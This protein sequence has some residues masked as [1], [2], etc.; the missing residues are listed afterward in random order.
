[1]SPE[2]A[3]C[4]TRA[5]SG[6]CGGGSSA[7]VLG[8]VLAGRPANRRAR[9]RRRPGGVLARRACGFRRG[10]GL[11]GHR[12]VVGRVA[13]GVKSSSVRRARR[14][15]A[16]RGAAAARG[17]LGLCLGGPPRLGRG[18][19]EQ[20]VAERGEAVGILVDGGRGDDQQ[21][22][23]RQQHEDRHDDEGARS[24][25]IA[26]E[27]TTKPIAPPASWS[28]SV[29][30]PRGCR[31]EV[32][33]AEDAEDQGGPADD[34]ASGRTGGLRVAHRGHADAEQDQRDEPAEQADRAVDHGAGGLPDAAGQPPPDGGGDDD[35]QGDEEQA[36]P[37]A[38]VL[39]SSSRAVCRDPA[40]DGAEGVG[41]PEPE[42]CRACR[43][44]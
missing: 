34:L 35:G 5:G 43:A 15:P 36:D 32:D 27:P 7:G 9:C 42:A 31:G 16:A 18:A 13:L 12:G 19:A 28:A 30:V 11:D 37:V 8:R 29:S 14:D 21:P 33:Q 2:S 41:D 1:M 23:D 6:V 25:S 17:L 24:R 26:S 3:S 39:G 44:R 10:L 20:P 40:Y 4:S 22:E 38:T